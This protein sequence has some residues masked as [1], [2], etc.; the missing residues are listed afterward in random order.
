MIRKWKRLFHGFKSTRDGSD[1]QNYKRFRNKLTRKIKKSK[2]EEIDRPT[3]NL[4]LNTSHLLQS[5]RFTDL[6]RGMFMLDPLYVHQLSIQSFCEV[7]YARSTLCP[8]KY[9]HSVGYLLR[10]SNK[11]INLTVQKFILRTKH[12]AI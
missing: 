8:T 5:N 3:D 6:R 7:A 10:G 9:S 1:F 4:K 2:K 12:I 11:E